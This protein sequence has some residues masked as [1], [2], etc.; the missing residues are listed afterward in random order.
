MKSKPLKEYYKKYKALMSVP[1]NI[2]PTLIVRHYG[3]FEHRDSENTVHMALVL[4][5]PG[6]VVMEDTT[7]NPMQM[8]VDFRDRFFQPIDDCTKERGK[9]RNDSRAGH[10]S[11][12]KSRGRERRGGGRI[13]IGTTNGRTGGR[14]NKR[15][16][17]NIKGRSH[18]K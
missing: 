8:Y 4:N 2:R 9:G 3:L 6:R 14:A 12:E 15:A 17:G 18:Q 13:R 10:Y 7:L 1:E 5:K 11:N 16:Q